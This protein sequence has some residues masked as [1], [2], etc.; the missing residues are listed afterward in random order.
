MAFELAIARLLTGWGIVSA[1]SYSE[2][3]EISLS[4]SLLLGRI[5]SRLWLLNLIIQRL[6]TPSL[7]DIVIDLVVFEAGS[8]RGWDRGGY[9]IPVVSLVENMEKDQCGILV[10]RVV[11]LMIDELPVLMSVHCNLTLID[12]SRYSPGPTDLRVR[13]IQRLVQSS[14]AVNYSCQITSF[15]LVALSV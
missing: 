5:C 8:Q 9:T 3:G 13:H 14:Q 7:V 4:K 6:A 15:K 11:V 1:S 10:D 12:R 2:T